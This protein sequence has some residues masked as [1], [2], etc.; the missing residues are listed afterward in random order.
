MGRSARGTQGR[1][2]RGE[3]ARGSS[4]FKVVCTK[5]L[6]ASP[7]IASGHLPGHNTSCCVITMCSFTVPMIAFISNT[8]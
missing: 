2:R 7:T 5:S 3:L 4:R 8:S 1:R 6:L